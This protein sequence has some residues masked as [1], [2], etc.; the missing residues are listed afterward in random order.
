MPAGAGATWRAQGADWLKT[1]AL[2]QPATTW[3]TGAM[4]RAC[5]SWGL[6]W[7]RGVI[8][9]SRRTK[10][11]TARSLT[12]TPRAACS[13]WDR[14]RGCSPPFSA[15]RGGRHGRSGCSKRPVGPLPTRSSASV[16]WATL[17][18]V[19]RVQGQS[20]GDLID[21]GSLGP[22]DL[23][24]RAPFLGRSVSGPR[25]GAAA[26]APPGVSVTLSRNMARSPPE[27]SPDFVN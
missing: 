4:P 22:Q 14:S 24:G 12:R 23:H 18:T 20:P 26:R 6:R 8:S 25:R 11:R 10:R 15:A 19:M 27:V 2:K 3:G 7:W 1:S 21:P 16:A 17:C 13:R 5:G 9:R